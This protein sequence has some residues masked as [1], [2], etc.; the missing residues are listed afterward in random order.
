MSILVHGSEV[1]VLSWP[2][3]YCT[4]LEVALHGRRTYSEGHCSLHGGQ[5]S[6]REKFQ[7]ATQVTLLMIS[8]MLS[9]RSQI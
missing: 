5:E 8:T 6:K 1:L 2:S 3:F 4:C 9:K 7:Y